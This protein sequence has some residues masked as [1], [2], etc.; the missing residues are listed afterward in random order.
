MKLWLGNAFLKKSISFINCFTAINYVFCFIKI[1]EVNSKKEIF[2]MKKIIKYALMFQK[3]TEFNR[4]YLKKLENGLYIL[5]HS[6]T[7]IF[8]GDK[9]FYTMYFEIRM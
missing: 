6:Y 2:V 9:K 8:L 1:N 7:D 3:P 4:Q 5:M